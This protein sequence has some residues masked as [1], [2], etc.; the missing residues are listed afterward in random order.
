[1]HNHDTNKNHNAKKL[2]GTLLNKSNVAEKYN[3]NFYL[4]NGFFSHRRMNDP[5]RIKIGGSEGISLEEKSDIGIKK[6]GKNLLEKRKE[7]N[8]AN[9]ISDI[10]VCGL[11]RAHTTS[12]IR[13]EIATPVMYDGKNNSTCRNLTHDG[14]FALQKKDSLGCSGFSRNIAGDGRKHKRNA[15]DFAFYGTQDRKLGES[16]VLGTSNVSEKRNGADP[17]MYNTFF[18][19][20]SLYHPDYCLDFFGVSG[21]D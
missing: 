12:G 7:C 2:I 16:K 9:A 10:K 14:N 8:K 13:T 4:S 19:K 20:S 3:E 6:F 18:D 21:K 11:D 17:K 5:K 15:S 1:M